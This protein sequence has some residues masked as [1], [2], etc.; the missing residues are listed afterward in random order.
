MSTADP[1]LGGRAWRRCAH[2]AAAVVAFARPHPPAGTSRGYCAFHAEHVAEQPGATLL[3]AGGVAVQL[4]LP[5]LAAAVDHANGIG[6]ERPWGGG[7]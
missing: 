2:P 6:R 5:S 7:R 3:A 4:A 1:T